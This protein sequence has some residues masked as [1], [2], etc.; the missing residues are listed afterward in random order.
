MRLPFFWLGLVSGLFTGIYALGTSPLGLAPDAPLNWD[1]ITDSAKM[2]A[3]RVF[4]FGAFEDES[5]DWLKA[6]EAE[7]G[8]GWGLLMRIAGSFQ[9][10]LAL[11]LVFVFGLA[12]RRRFQIS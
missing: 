12:V 6:Y 8:A 2:S 9:S 10:A 4:P 3:A 11:A 5:K 1:V 7:H